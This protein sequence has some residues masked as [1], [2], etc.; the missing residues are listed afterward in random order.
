M[1]SGWCPTHFTSFAAA[2]AAI[3]LN[4]TELQTWSA[5]WSVTCVILS[6]SWILAVNVDPERPKPWVTCLVQAVQEP[7]MS[8]FRSLQH[9]AVRTTS[10]RVSFPEK[11]PGLRLGGRSDVLPTSLKQQRRRRMVAQWTFSSRATAISG[12]IWIFNKLVL[13]IWK[14]SNLLCAWK[15]PKLFDSTCEKW[16]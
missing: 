16:E 5:R 11:A 14:K 4:C 13:K 9:G 1:A 6:R 2:R 7:G 15:S 12:S 8:P 10:V 3:V